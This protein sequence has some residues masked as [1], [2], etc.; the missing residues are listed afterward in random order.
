MCESDLCETHREGAGGDLDAVR[1]DESRLTAA[2]S[3]ISSQGR[4]CGSTR[5]SHFYDFWVMCG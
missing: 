5:R 1:K 3:K 4:G 2:S